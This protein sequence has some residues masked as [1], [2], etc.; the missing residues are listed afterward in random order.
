M[1]KRAYFQGEAV[2]LQDFLN[3]FYESQGIK[4]VPII[5]EEIDVVLRV[6]EEKHEEMFKDWALSFGLKCTIIETAR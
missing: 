1:V 2:Q 6:K 5:G 3:L 4:E